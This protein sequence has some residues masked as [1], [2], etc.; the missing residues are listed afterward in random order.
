MMEIHT[1]KSQGSLL[2]LR[3]DIVADGRVGRCSIDCLRILLVPDGSLLLAISPLPGLICLHT[4]FV[5]LPIDSYDS[6]WHQLASFASF[7][8]F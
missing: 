3:Q 2:I 5:C 1:S 4:D 6:L 7:A 8:P